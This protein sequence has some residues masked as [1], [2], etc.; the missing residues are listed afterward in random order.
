MLLR[1]GNHDISRLVHD[2]HDAEA[3]CG[4]DLLADNELCRQL[5]LSN[6]L[7]PSCESTDALLANL[8]EGPLRLLRAQPRQSLDRR[9][10]RV[11]WEQVEHVRPAPVCDHPSLP[12]LPLGDEKACVSLPLPLDCNN[13]AHARQTSEEPQK[14][15]PV[16]RPASIKKQ[17]P[18]WLDVGLPLQL[19]ARALDVLTRIRQHLR[20]ERGH[21]AQSCRAAEP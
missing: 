14:A 11:G 18:I 9:H 4:N 21:E 7:S 2:A 13:H 8:V 6:W 10:R 19:V 5:G 3:P 17:V 12:C 15:P 16:L 1:L 20:R